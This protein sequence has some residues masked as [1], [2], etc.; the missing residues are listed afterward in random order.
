MVNAKFKA[1]YALCKEKVFV[2]FFFHVVYMDVLEEFLMATFAEERPSCHAIPSRRRTFAYVS[3]DLQNRKL[4]RKWFGRGGRFTW[5]PRS[6]E[7]ALPDSFFWRCIKDAHCV[8]TSPGTLPKLA[9]RVGDSAPGCSCDAHKRVDWTV[10]LT[11]A[12]RYSQ[13]LRSTSVNRCVGHKCLVI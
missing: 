13:C 12:P 3:W 9:L 11:N 2:H 4:R 7:F 6:P 1:F 10:T 8:A 5:S